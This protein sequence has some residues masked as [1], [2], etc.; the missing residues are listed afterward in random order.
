MHA[1][2]FE[3]RK[4]VLQILGAIADVGSEREINGLLH[5]RPPRREDG[6][7]NHNRPPPPCF[8]DLL[9]LKTFKSNEFGSADSKGVTGANRGS[10]H[11]KGVSGFERLFM[12]YYTVVVNGCQEKSAVG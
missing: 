6:E 8:L 5:P 10:A 1:F 12:E 9:I 11:S 7:V 3:R 2:G 4:R